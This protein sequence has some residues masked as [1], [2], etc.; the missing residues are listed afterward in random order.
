MELKE[1]FDGNCYHIC[2]NGNN[3]PILLRDKED[4]KVVCNYLAVFTWKLKIQMLAYII[5]SNHLHMIIVCTNRE[6]AESFTR[7]LKQNIASYLRHKYGIEKCFKSVDHCISIIDSCKYLRNCIAYVLRNAI[8]A[9]ICNRIEDYPWSSYSAYFSFS[10]TETAIRRMSQLSFRERRKILKTRDEYYDA[11]LY[12]D[13]SG[14]IIND[15]FVRNDIVERAYYNSGR[16]F[17]TCLGTCND[18]DIEYALAIKPLIKV[19][20]MNLMDTVNRVVSDRFN[21][22]QLSNL[23]NTDKCKIIKNLYFNNKTS[24]SQLSRVLGLPKDLISQILST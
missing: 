8:C 13:S 24:V 11:P 1:L 23:T 9:K 15:C 6:Q 21:G 10:N 12:V 4:Y 22:K 19:D 7:V 18:A 20:D 5:M 2:T 17:L 3:T 16:H 14:R